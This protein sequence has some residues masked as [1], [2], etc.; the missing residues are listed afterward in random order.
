MKNTN[1]TY[2]FTI[3][4]FYFLVLSSFGQ[5]TIV[6]GTIVDATNG[7]SLPFV[8]VFFNGTKI[9]TTT[10]FDGHYSIE[11]YYA[12]DSLVASFVGYKTQ[13]IKIKKDKT[14]EINFKLEPTTEA[15]PEVVI[16]PTG[17]PAH[18]IIKNVIRY[19][20]ANNREKLDAYQY[21]V[22]N[23][24][25]FDI[26]NLTEDFK[27]KKVFRKFD[28]I[29][30]N[31]DTT[32]EKDY[33]PVFIT[34]SVSDVYYR[35]KPKAQKEIIKASKVSGVNNK[36]VAQFT[37]DMYQQVNLY[38]NF[39][40]IFGKNFVSPIANKGLL[41]YR[42]YLED[43]MFID[44]RWCYQIQFV[45]RRKNEMT[46]TGRM[47]INDTTYA[48]KKIEGEISPGANI[49]FVK[50]LKFKQNYVFVNNE[51]WMLKKDHLF[52]DFVLADKAMGF[53]G[54]KTA[55]YKD[56]IV[57][58]P[59]EDEFYEGLERIVVLDSA[60]S[61]DENYWRTARHDSLTA[62]QEGIYQMIDTLSNLPII[63]S[64]VDI[65]QTIVSGYKVIGKVEIGPYMSMYSNNAVEGSRVR[66]GIRTSNDFSKKI[67]F[68]GFVAYGFKDEELK[69]GVGTRF[70]ITKKPRQLV[71][72]VYK[73]D[74]EQIGL[75]TNA[76]NN[77]NA[78]STLFVRN[79][80]NRLVFNTDYRLSYE[81]EWI[82]GLS[83]TLLLR[84]NTINP[85]GI[86]TFYRNTEIPNVTEALKGITATE[87]TLFTRFAR[88][89]EYLAGEF[90][91]VS[92]GTKAPI[93]TLNYT[94]GMKGVLNSE[95]EYHKVFLG[96]KHKLKLGYFG[97]LHYTATVGKIFG[98][99]PYPLLEI[100]RG[101]ESI[102][103][104]KNAYNMM[105]ILEF[106]SDEY[107]SGNL[108]HHFNGLFLNKV[109][110]LKRLKWRE[111]V[112]VKGIWG[113]MSDKNIALMNLP[114]YTSS[115]QAKPYLEAS[116]GIENIFKFLRVDVLWRM[117][118][119]DHQFYGIQVNRIG[120]R[121][122]FQF[123]F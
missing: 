101:N 18:P 31:I 38:E 11:T 24:L 94:Y 45:P 34:E 87:V 51:A 7:D 86:I 65:I 5:K 99:A 46:L 114:V 29:F 102:M 100:H 69:Y 30:D 43:S 60:D 83:T 62:N 107:V 108:E 32:L 1:L 103:G 58:Q 52:V 79:P 121:G 116:A 44:N 84:N 105:N 16:T 8:N 9:G 119:L 35:R 28:F 72:I 71:N 81:R 10:D 27:N 17:N 40:P 98:S 49:N 93:I 95:Y 88:N 113:T 70:F 106:V 12:S 14:Q 104:N 82:K 53:Y 6:S 22:Y 55:S 54:Q 39:V 4:V 21:E 90:D 76:F 96:Y 77:S 37:G 66:F 42:Y 50:E 26:N 89:E 36:S 63:T 47:W 112:G 109:P 61:R 92:L 20:D 117:N 74:V 3:V 33:L 23:K 67:E 25:E 48:I 91:R 110:L 123:H 111:V 115:L 57:N 41:S 15:L 118:Y 19:K 2:L 68:S 97:V 122:R 120:I 80:I 73:H 59:K 64:Y 56:I 13:K 78:L 85:L 75:S